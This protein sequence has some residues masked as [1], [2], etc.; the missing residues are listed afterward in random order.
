LAGMG[1]LLDSP[2]R[3]AALL[4]AVVAIVPAALLIVRLMAGLREPGATPGARALD[5]LWTVLPLAGLGALV[6]LAATA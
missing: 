3:A 6:A 1:A 5:A 2:L 4:L